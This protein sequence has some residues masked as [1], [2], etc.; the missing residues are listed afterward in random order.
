MRH[1]AVC[2]LVRENEGR[3]EVCLSTKKRKYGARLLHGYG[4]VIEKLETTI[5]CAVR[6]L[7][8][9]SG[10]VAEEKHLQEVAH[11]A[12]YSE[13]PDNH[14]TLHVY[15]CRQ[16]A[17]DPAESDECGPPEWYP[18]NALPYE[19][20]FADRKYWLAR[21][22]RGEYIRA[23]VLL[24]KDGHEPHAYFSS[25]TDLRSRYI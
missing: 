9:E 22:L 13:G 3:T 8:E 10:V 24:S 17:G 11:I 6:E 5:A 1:A 19:R 4:G 16:W 20:L 12:T 15:I 2:Y 7:Q 21:S 14:W 18:V 25:K 23:S